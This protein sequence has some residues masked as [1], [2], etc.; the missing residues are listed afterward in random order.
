[1]VIDIR[2]GR[3][4]AWASVDSQGRDLVSEPYG[5]PASLFKVVTAAALL[6]HSNVRSST[7]QCYVGGH[8]AVHLRDLRKSGAGGAR[9]STFFSAVGY[10]HNMVMAGLAVRFLE[11]NHLEDD[12][13]Q[14]R[15]QR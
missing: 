15:D 6:E 11:P 5:P 7:R 8:R 12:G 13:R 3:V 4:L 14:A 9:C 10:S 2:T 1:M